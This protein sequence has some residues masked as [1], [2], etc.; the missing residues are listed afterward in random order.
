MVNLRVYFEYELVKEAEYD[1][2]IERINEYTFVVDAHW[3]EELYETHLRQLF[4]YDCY[5]DEFL[6][7]YDPDFEGTIIY[8]LAQNQNKIKEEG[9]CAVEPTSF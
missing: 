8:M 5:I 4:G 1:D 7:V 9:W 2:N 3:L 6:D